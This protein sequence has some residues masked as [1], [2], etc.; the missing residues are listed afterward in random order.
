MVLVRAPNGTPYCI[1]TTEVTQAQYQ[2]FLVKVSGK[3]GTEH[4][5]WVQIP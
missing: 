3:P 1:D 4:P 5:E 2:E